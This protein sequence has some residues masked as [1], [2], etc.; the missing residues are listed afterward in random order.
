M[1]RRA[2]PR[3]KVSHSILYLSEIYPSPRVASTVDLSLGGTKIETFYSLTSGEYLQV[4][5]AIHP[6][7]IKCKGKV[8][9]T[10]QETGEKLKAGIQFKEMSDGD[11]IYLRQY[12]FHV[13]EQQAISYLSSEKTPL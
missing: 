9:Y 2:Y 12:L 8:V 1:E 3:V 5:V 4:S 10:Q 7:V 13:V 11:K 6:Q